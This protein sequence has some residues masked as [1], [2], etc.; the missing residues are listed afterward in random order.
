[1]AYVPGF[2]N[3]R[4]F[5]PFAA[6]PGIIYGLIYL[7]TNRE[8]LVSI[9]EAK[10]NTIGKILAAMGGFVLVVTILFGYSSNTFFGSGGLITLGGIVIIVSERLGKRF[11]FRQSPYF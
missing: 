8:K 1:M 3:K 5:D 2:P 4:D 7:F 11:R 9:I 10:G 6:L